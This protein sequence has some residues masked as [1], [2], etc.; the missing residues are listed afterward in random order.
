[1]WG[2]AECGHEE[3]EANGIHQDFTCQTTASTIVLVVHQ[4]KSQEEKQEINYMG[5][6]PA[7]L[8]VNLMAGDDHQDK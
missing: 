1:M 4:K 5:K 8:K 7:N 6:S 2:E 3:P